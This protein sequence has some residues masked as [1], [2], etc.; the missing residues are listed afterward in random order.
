MHLLSSLFTG[1][2]VD[3]TL[4]FGREEIKLLHH[5][6]SRLKGLKRIVLGWVSCGYIMCEDERRV[7]K[8]KFMKSL[9]SF[10]VKVEVISV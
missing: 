6:L 4:G 10:E 7:V 9:G 1:L 2:H 8:E 3:E 5:L